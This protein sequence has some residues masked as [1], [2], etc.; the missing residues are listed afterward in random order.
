MWDQLAALPVV[1][2]ALLRMLQL[3]P[4]RPSKPLAQQGVAVASR[5]QGQQVLLR[6]HI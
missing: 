6:L 1:Y 3:L 5:Q 4:D 2:Y